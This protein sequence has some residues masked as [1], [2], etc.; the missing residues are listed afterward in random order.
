MLGFDFMVD[1]VF[2]VYLIEVNLDPDQSHSTSL[3]SQLV[4]V[5]VNSLIDIV[6]GQNGGEKEVDGTFGAFNWVNI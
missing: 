3:T 6:I 1:K 4:P 5:A 2:K